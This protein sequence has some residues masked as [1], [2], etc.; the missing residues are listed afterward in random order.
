MADVFVAPGESADGR[1]WIA[2]EKVL[3]ERIAELSDEIDFLREM[4]RIALTHNTD[5]N[6]KEGA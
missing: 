2:L 5:S 3:Q 1:T 6:P 4:L